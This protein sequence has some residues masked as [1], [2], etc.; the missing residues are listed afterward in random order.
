MRIM[1]PVKKDICKIS[2]NTNEQAQ[3]V[4]KDASVD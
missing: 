4:G 2:H 1:K 3:K